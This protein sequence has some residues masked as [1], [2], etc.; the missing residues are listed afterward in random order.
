[1][2]GVLSIGGTKAHADNVTLYTPYSGLSVS[3]GENLTYNVDVM[4]GSGTVQHVTFNVEKLPKD[5]DYSIRA[6]GLAIDQLSIRPNAEEEITV[7]VNVPLKVKKG[8][9]TFELLA[10]ANDG[11]TSTLPFLV[12]I[13]EEGTFKTEFNVEQP[14]MQG[15][16]DSSFSYSATLKNQTADSQH[17]ALSAEFPEGWNV[18][19]KVDGSSV[20]SI[21]I[22]P[23][24][25]KDITIDVTP[26]ENVKADTY[27]I[28]VVASTGSTSSDVELEAVITGKY[29][30]ELT[31]PDGKLS[32]DVTAGRNK[33]VQ[34]V[35]ENTGS[36]ELK[37]IKLKATAPPE[38]E[39]NF[40]KDTIQT[41][42][43][44]EQAN[45]KAT[46]EA[47]NDAIAGDYVTTFSAE[48]SEVSSDANFR[49]SVKTSTMWGLISVG[50]ILAV[51]G[52]LYV[53]FKKYGRR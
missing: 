6:G 50:I 9:Y 2:L 31:T 27:V 34:L 24:E 42:G 39:V 13:S 18:E 51:V 33:S 21:T 43:A 47:P 10:K 26:A 49:V 45:V 44:G 32:S 38:W 7:E 30:M 20:T 4:N 41:L 12:N 48:S 1:M 52:G 8:E 14:N 15:H 35:V 40:D 22:E 36:A 25:S 28:P 53:I 11:A 3:P 17:Y 37:D 46:I 23:N 19:F 16:T 29:D 5:W